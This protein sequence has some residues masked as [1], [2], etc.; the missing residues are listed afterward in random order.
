VSPL[1]TAEVAA[2]IGIHPIT[3]EHWIRD[4]KAK[5]SK[6]VRVG[7]QTFRLWT[8][9]DVRRLKKFKAAHYWEGRGGKKGSRN[10]DTKKSERSTPA[11]VRG[12]GPGRARNS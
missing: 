4:G 9:A 10:E 7:K 1:S 12:D 8:P 6:T 3:L 2:L 5:P 11:R